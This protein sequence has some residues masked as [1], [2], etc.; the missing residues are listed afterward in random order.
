[1]N[2][3]MLMAAMAALLSGQS[4]WA[5]VQ[6]DS[7]MFTPQQ[8]DGFVVKRAD[9]KLTYREP[10]IRKVAASVPGETPDIAQKPQDTNNAEAAW[11]TE[12][13]TATRTGQRLDDALNM[14][15]PGWRIEGTVPSVRVSWRAMNEP[16]GAVV[17]RV[18]VTA[19]IDRYQVDSSRFILRIDYNSRNIK[20]ET[21]VKVK[22]AVKPVTPTFVVNEG[23]TL[24]ATLERW[25]KSAGY[26][27]VWAAERNDDLTLLAGNTYT[28]PIEEVVPQFMDSLEGD[29]HVKATLQTKNNPK[30][31]YVFKAK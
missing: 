5:D 21:T 16:R 31:L 12:R 28:G 10:E 19:G 8:N 23:E 18:L 3:T 1:M 26:K 2:K 25:A 20:A 15:L 30:L 22:M 17:R 29:V 11:E 9:S 7:T 24:S 6:F 13:I 4:C 14:I 27:M